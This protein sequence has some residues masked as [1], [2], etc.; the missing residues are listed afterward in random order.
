MIGSRHS[1]DGITDMSDASRSGRHNALS[2]DFN[3]IGRY[4][5]VWF[6]AGRSEKRTFVAGCLL[7]ASAPNSDVGGLFYASLKQTRLINCVAKAAPI[8]DRFTVRPHS[9]L[10]GKNPD[11]IVITSASDF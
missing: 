1:A 5:T 4:R 2:D 11:Q 9:Q 10:G 3:S 6:G 7:A 8:P